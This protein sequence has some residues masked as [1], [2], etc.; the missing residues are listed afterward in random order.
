[1]NKKLEALSGM[2]QWFPPLPPLGPWSPLTKSLHYHPNDPQEV[3]IQSYLSLE[4][5]WF[6]I[7]LQLGHRRFSFM[8]AKNLNHPGILQTHTSLDSWAHFQFQYVGSS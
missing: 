6:P 5:E 4:Q 8:L 2:M 1:M 7:A 3:A